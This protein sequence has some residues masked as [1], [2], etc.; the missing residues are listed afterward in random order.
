M[1]AKARG[2][3]IGH[4]GSGNPG[5]NNAARLMGRSTGVAV[6]AVD[7]LKGLIP[8]L[9]F[10]AI[11]G[12]HVGAFAGLMAILGH[13]TSPFLRGR[14]GK[15]VAT[16]LGV[17]VGIEP[18]WALVVVIAFAIVIALTKRTGIA[19]VGGALALIVAAL[20][21][22]NDPE[23]SIICVLVGILVIFRHQRNIRAAWVDWL[24]VRE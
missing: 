22:H 24:H 5:A 2:I 10:T 23:T 17:L 1:I 6:L 11:A 15:G 21:D 4:S 20:V 19:S 7:L 16:T 3:D 12:P 8:V 9:V 18:W 13:M 14:G